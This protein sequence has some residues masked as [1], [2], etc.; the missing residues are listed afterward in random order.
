MSGHIHV[1]DISQLSITAYTFAS[2]IVDS[3]ASRHGAN[4]IQ[5]RETR[6]PLPFVVYRAAS[7]SSSSL[8]GR[9][10]AHSAMGR[11]IDPSWWSHLAISRSCQCSTTVVTKAVVCAILSVGWCI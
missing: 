9:A 3:V 1:M 4:E 8:V 6:G 11:P 7:P 10:F 5:F 2:V